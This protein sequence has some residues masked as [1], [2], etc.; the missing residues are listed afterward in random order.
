MEERMLSVTRRGERQLHVSFTI[1]RTSARSHY[2]FGGTG[3]PA[4]RGMSH[5]GSRLDPGSEP[6]A[7]DLRDFRLSTPSP[8]RRPGSREE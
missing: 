7:V 3:S 1:A 6:N 8:R 5:Q 2:F 4:F